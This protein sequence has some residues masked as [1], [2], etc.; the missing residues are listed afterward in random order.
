MLEQTSRARRRS[1]RLLH[2][3]AGALAAL[4]VL[5]VASPAQAVRTVYRGQWQCDDRG[6]IMPLGGIEVQLWRRGADYL[7]VEW[8]GRVDDRAFANPDGTFALTATN[9]IDNHF[10][11]M[12]LRDA[13]GVHLKDFWGSNDW[14]VDSGGSRNNVGV[15]NVGGLLLSTPGQSH[16]CAIWR[17]FHLAHRDFRDLTGMNPPSGGLT[18]NADAITAGVPF[19]PHTTIM[20]P[21]GFPAGYSGGGDDTITRH[22]FGHVIR[23]GYDGDLGHFLGDV[24]AHNYAQNHAPCNKTGLGFAFNEGWAEFWARDYGP[25]P[26]CAGRA[27]DDFEVEGNVAAALTDIETRCYGG[28]RAAMVD[29]LRANPGTIHSYQE[30]LSHVVCPAP[31]V[32]APPAPVQTAPLRISTA[33]GAALAAAQ[34]AAVNRRLRSLRADLR[35]AVRAA[36]HVAPCTSAPCNA[37]LRRAMRPAVLRTS[38]ALAGIVRRS[39]DGQ[40]TVKEQEVLGN[41]GIGDA[42]NRMKAKEKANRTRAAR[43]SA[44]GIRDALKAGR[45]IFGTDKSRAT[46]RLRSLLTARMAAFRKVQKSTTGDPGPVLGEAI[47]ERI[48]RVTLKPFPNPEPKPV[49][50]A[51]PA[52]PPPP[53]VDPRAVSTLTL[54]CPPNGKAGDYAYTGNLSPVRPGVEVELHFTPPG[55]PEVVQ[56]ATTDQAS[57]YSAGH[58]TTA[59]LWTVFAR[60]AGDAQT[61]PDDSPTC[62]TTFTP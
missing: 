37:A 30:F 61:Q 54:T 35:G 19:T 6:T 23:H 31:V 9:D 50:P 47:V 7:P 10:V 53:P 21:G 5:A 32:A 3:V 4:S 14:S 46:R 41:L 1:P 2:V 51:P 33:Q 52:P 25:A 29:I 20:W 16:K 8:V 48:R 24:L 56:K 18:V 44:D 42:L 39:V 60:W 59:G 13:A 58:T 12:A 15:Q 28:R 57:A 49:P 17:G 36:A 40:D 45:R 43:A 34:L 27:L 55:L 11:R 22:E 38:I 62:Q 26:G